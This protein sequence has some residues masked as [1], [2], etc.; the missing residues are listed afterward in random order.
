MWWL[1]IWLVAVFVAG[2]LFLFFPARV[3]DL[4]FPGAKPSRNPFDTRSSLVVNRL[5]GLVFLAMSGA[6]ADSLLVG[7]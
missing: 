4:L 7:R 3:R 1:P 6:V 2:L 5:V